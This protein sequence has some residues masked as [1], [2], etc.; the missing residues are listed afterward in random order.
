MVRIHTHIALVP[1]TY[2][3]YV[4][5]IKVGGSVEVRGLE[6]G[7]VAKRNVQKDPNLEYYAFQPYVSDKV[8]CA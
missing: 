3:K 1:A 6:L 4:D 7:R 5:V 2:Y 8:G